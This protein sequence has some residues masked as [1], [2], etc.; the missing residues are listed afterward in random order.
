VLALARA[1]NLDRNG[2][3]AK[4]QHPAGD[5]SSHGFSLTAGEEAA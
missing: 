3:E 2:H 1:M 4:G 5:R